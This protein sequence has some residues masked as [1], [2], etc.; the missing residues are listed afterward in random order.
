MARLRVKLGA[1]ESNYQTIQELKRKIEDKDIRYVIIFYDTLL[2]SYLIRQR[3]PDNFEQ[4]R[5]LSSVVYEA[6]EIAQQRERTLNLLEEKLE[7][8]IKKFLKESEKEISELKDK[9]LELLREKS[10][11]LVLKKLV[12]EV[13]NL[14][15]NIEKDGLYEEL[16][17]F[18]NNL[19]LM[20]KFGKELER[21]ISKHKKEIKD[22][23]KQKR[24]ARIFWAEADYIEEVVKS[25]RY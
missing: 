19:E 1:N 15:N 14:S 20:N 11:K 24:N 8:K 2:G 21:K 4:G 18:K 9:E 25:S 7:R 13:S 17:K 6:D 3:R 22:I 12:K 10:V 5:K 23:N 16:E